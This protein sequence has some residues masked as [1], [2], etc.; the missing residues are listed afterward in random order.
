MGDKSNKSDSEISENEEHT[1]ISMPA[2]LA[3]KTSYSKP[4]TLDQF[5]H[6]TDILTGKSR[7]EYPTTMVAI[8]NKDGVN[9]RIIQDIRQLNLR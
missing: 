7:G 2:N 5:M 1:P 9:T 6:A 4:M 3:Q 8:A